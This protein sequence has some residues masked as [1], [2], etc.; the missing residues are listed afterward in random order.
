VWR[1]ARRTCRTLLDGPD[2]VQLDVEGDRLPRYLEPLVRLGPRT[3]VV[4]PL[5]FRRQLVGMLMLGDRSGTS[6]RAEAQCRSAASPIRWPSRWPTRG[7]WSRSAPWHTTT[8]SPDCRTASPIRRLAQQALDHARRNG[9]LVAAFFI[10]LDHFSRIS[11]TLGHE[12]GDQLAK[13]ALRLRACCGIG[14]DEVGPARPQSP[15]TW[16]VWV[17]TSS[18]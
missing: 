17:A 16:R 4:L 2:V 15:P 10:D 18:R 3:V 1:F 6:A 14:R 7:C 9:K 12:A 8:A 13:V 5:R 11:D